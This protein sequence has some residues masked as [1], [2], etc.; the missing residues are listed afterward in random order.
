MNREIQLMLV[1]EP[2][3]PAQA[4]A[5]LRV[6]DPSPTAS[7]VWEEVHKH[8]KTV[9]LEGYTR[10]AWAWK[11]GATA[12]T[13]L[14]VESRDGKK[15][16]PGFNKYLKDRQKCAYGRFLLGG[17]T[18]IWVVSYVQKP[19][20]HEDR[21]ESR[22]CLDLTKIP[23]CT[24]SAAPPKATRAP[25][26][27]TAATAAGAPVRKRSGA[28][29]L[30]KLVGAQK[31]T[32]SHVAVAKA[33]RPVAVAP[34]ATTT[35]GIPV[36]QKT[37]VNVLAEF[38]NEMEQK[39]MD[40]DI[41]AESEFKVPLSLSKYTAGLSEADLP[42]VTMEILKYMVYEAA[43]EV[44]E[45]WIS[46][47]EPSEFMDEVTIVVYKEGCAP[48]EVL[49][50]MNKAEL[51]EEA[52]AQQRALQ[53]ERQRQISAAERKRDQELEL[54]AHSAFADDEDD[55]VAALNANKRDRRTL[56][57]YEREKKKSRSS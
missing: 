53:N 57:D 32:N 14:V 13:S 52:K 2:G 19:T 21:M 20:G 26:P 7:K 8:S 6:V 5:T 49:E 27:P 3:K 10:D 37:A 36:E 22:I 28:G 38:R 44:N 54:G 41:S 47:K 46:H 23:G 40:F 50:E 4:L 56:E 42:K 33:P 11:P 1:P 24:L 45:E 48:P 43:E 39:M 18:G 16:L 15:K 25:P 55:G 17:T 12:W 30:G 29:L 35:G 9:V 34:E 31:K 51:P